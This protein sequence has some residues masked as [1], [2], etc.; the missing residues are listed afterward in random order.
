MKPKLQQ[1]IEKSLGEDSARVDELLA[2]NDSL[3]GMIASPQGT[4]ASAVPLTRRASKEK[5][6]G[7]T[8]DI[9]L[10]DS[11][12]LSPHDT[13][14]ATILPNGHAHGSPSTMDDFDEESASTP[15]LD[16]GKQRA[17]EEPEQ[18]TPVLRRPSLVLD[19]EGGFV[20][21]EVHPEAGISPTVDRSVIQKPAHV[22][23]AP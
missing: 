13:P 1:L 18:P 10:Y 15:R 23:A 5:G 6:V 12:F 2:L 20:E 4:L 19:E 21:P 7:L 14:T 8:V 3:T 22:H 11:S 9:P 17:T 16:K